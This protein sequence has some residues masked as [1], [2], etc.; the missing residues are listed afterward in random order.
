MSFGA[1]SSAAPKLKFAERRVV[2]RVAGKAL[3]VHNGSDL[4]EPTLRTL[5]PSN[6]DGAAEATTGDGRMVIN[7]S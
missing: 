7:V 4:V 3:A 2:E 1:V 6:R 5:M